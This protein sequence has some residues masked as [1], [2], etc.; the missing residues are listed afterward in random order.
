MLDASIVSELFSAFRWAYLI[1]ALVSAIVVWRL[2]PLRGLKIGGAIL[3]AA[4]FAYWP[5]SEIIE[6]RRQAAEYMTRYNA[7]KARFD[8]RCKGA[9]ERIV[10]TVDSVEGVLL[11]KLRTSE[12][13]GDS[14]DPMARSAAFMGDS[15]GDFYIR[16]FLSYEHKSEEARKLGL[17]GQLSDAFSD[18]PGY[19]YIDYVDPTNNERY[20]Y[21]LR[22]EH[23]A[24]QPKTNRTV[25]FREL[26]D[27]PAPRY[28]VTFEDLVNP[29]DRQMWIAGSVVSIVDMES[30]QIIAQHTRYA[31]DP[32]L[33]SQ[34]DFRQPW[35]FADY[36]PSL[37]VIGPKTRF[38]VDRILKPKKG[39]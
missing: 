32:G 6:H 35:L 17:R 28:G 22:Q 12:D 10:R 11:L 39:N 25:I 13:R 18:S 19:A 29:Q 24:D 20:R 4:L 37:K 8:E 21:R 15:F 31:F 16:T 7:A 30:N 33:G 9:G 36:C 2:I 5:V 3:V 1:A 23:Y 26:A 14:H 27:G 38:F 34:S